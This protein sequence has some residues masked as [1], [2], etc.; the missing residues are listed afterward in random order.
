L[1]GI[2]VEELEVE[3][4]RKEKELY[5][6]SKLGLFLAQEVDELITQRKGIVSD[7]TKLLLELQVNDLCNSLAQ[8]ALKIYLQLKNSKHSI[9][10]RSYCFDC[11]HLRVLFV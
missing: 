8:S 9:F 11:I 1:H 7:H 4:R 2:S 3:L 6:C 10:Y 5:L